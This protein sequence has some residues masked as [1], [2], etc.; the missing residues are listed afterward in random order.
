MNLWSEPATK[1]RENDAGLKG[2]ELLGQACERLDR[3][4]HR[5]TFDPL[6]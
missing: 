4:Q 5:S 3:V 1:A 2:T 6:S